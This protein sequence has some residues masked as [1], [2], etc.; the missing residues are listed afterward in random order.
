MKGGEADEQSR[1]TRIEKFNTCFTLCHCRDC[2]IK[3]NLYK[4]PCQ[5]GERSHSSRLKGGRS[6]MTAWV[7]NLFATVIVTM[8]AIYIVKKISIDYNVP[9]MEDVAETI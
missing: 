3:N 9:Y 2:R 8:I 7:L 1:W 4:T 6:S 5:G